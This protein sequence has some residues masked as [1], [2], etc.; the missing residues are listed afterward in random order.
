[1]GVALGYPIYVVDID[2]ASNRVTLGQR[3]ALLK[4]S[5]VAHQVNVLSDRLRAEPISCTAKIR[6]NHP[7][8]PAVARLS[9]SDELSV[10]FDQPQSAVTPGQAVV[11]YD[12]DVVLGGGWID[13]AA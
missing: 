6:Y 13:S 1:V 9:A 5:L 2:A 10:V 12:G 4:T 8:Q 7:P 11:L 3:D